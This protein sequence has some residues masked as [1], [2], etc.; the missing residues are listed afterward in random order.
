MAK[1]LNETGLQRALA[2][3]WARVN[4]A[5]S[6]I[7]LTPGPPGPKGDKG[8]KGDTGNTGAT[9]PAG[10]K[11]VAFYGWSTASNLTN[12]SSVSGMAV[13]DYVVNSGTATRTMLGLST[14]IGGVVKST[15]ATAGT[16]AGNIRGATGETG[17]TG[18]QGPQGI[19]GPAGTANYTAPTTGPLANMT[20]TNAIA[21]INQLLNGE[22]KNII[23]DVDSI[24]VPLN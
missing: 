24:R 12:I 1:Y 13:G 2:G 22:H 8:D 18:A 20:L 15:S 5:L 6:A 21:Y 16:A 7:S 11:G 17:A 19:Q 9:G 4:Q 23:L 3:L 10:A 14:D